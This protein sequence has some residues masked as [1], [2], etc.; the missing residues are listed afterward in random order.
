MRI[1]LRNKTLL[2]TGSTQGLGLCIAGMAVECGVSRLVLT[3]RNAGR[4]EAAAERLSSGGS[5]CWFVE[6]DLSLPQGPR[7]LFDDAQRVAGAID[8]LV[9][10]AGL[11]NRAS[12]LDGSLETWETLFN[13]NAR[14]PFFLMQ[15]L[16]KSLLARNAPGSVVNIQSMNAHC[17]TPDLAI[18]AATKGALSTL[19]KN[20]A[21]AFLAAGIRVN[22][23]N[24]GW[25]P[26]DA[27]MTMQ[28][29]TLG[30]GTGWIEEASRHMP[31][32]RMLK[33]EEVAKVALFLLS[34]LSIPMTGVGL[35]LEQTV[36]GSPR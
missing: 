14:A 8:L 4:G 27:E 3:G 2:V 15:E 29:E 21:N 7:K 20:A 11:T 30:K 18:Y 16:I 33:P 34:D 23:I 1:D 13:V 25:A 9:N 35:D 24:M 17:G 5:Q 19:T 31:L 28:A 6:S 12:I 10:S 32:K 22:G 36:V 26:T